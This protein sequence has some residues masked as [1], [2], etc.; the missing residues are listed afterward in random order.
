MPPMMPTIVEPTPPPLSKSLSARSS[1]TRGLENGH[2]HKRVFIGPMPEKVVAQ[3]DT[4]KGKKRRKLRIGSTDDDDENISH[5]I[6][7]HAF[8]FFIQ[9]G[10]NEED[11]EETREQ[12]VR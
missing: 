5:I 3:A 2:A 6:K 1:G 10:G 4:A 8:A 11:W 7:E 9:Q 12:S